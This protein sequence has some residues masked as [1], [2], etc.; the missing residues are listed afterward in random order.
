MSELWYQKPAIGWDEALPVGNGRLGAML[1]EDSVWY[2]GP[3][4]RL[5]EDALKNLPRLRELIRQG[6]HKQAEQLRH[7]EPLGTLSLEFGHSF[8]QVASYR[9]S[10]DLNEGIAHVQ[11]EYNGVQFHRQVLASHPDG[12]LAIRIQASRHTEFLVRL[13][14]LSDLEYE[15][16]EFLDELSVDDRSITMQVTPGGKDSNRA[17]CKVAIRCENGD[18]E[19]ARIERVG[20]NLVVTARDVLVLVA[21]Q[22]TYRHE[23]IIRA[24]TADLDAAL[25]YSIDDIWRRHIT[26][27][28]ALYGRLELQLSPDATYKPTDER[29]K[30]ERDPGLFALYLH[31]S[32]YLLISCSRP[33]KKDGSDRVLPAT[34]QGIW[35]PSFHPPWGC[36]YTININLQ[37]NYWPANVGNLS[38]CERPLFSL[39]ERLA[40]TGA[41]T[42]RKM[43]GCRGWTVHH[44]TDIWADTAP[45]D[46]WMP[47][48]LWPLGGAWLCFHIWEHFRFTGDQIS[49]AHLFPV[50]RGCVEFL[51][52]F[53]V[54]D[55]SGQY[56]V[57]NPSL[58]P[59]NT[60]RAAQGEAGVLCEGSTIDVQL[61]RA[62]L[63]AFVAA[64]EVLGLSQDELLP[65]VKE[66]LLRLPPIRIGSAGQLQEWMSDY[67]EL[68]PGHRHVSHLWALYPGKDITVDT[69]PELAKACAVTLRR[70][71]AAGG[72]HTGWS[73]AW[74]L[75]L[76]ARLRDVNECSSHLERLL[77]DST[78]PNLLDTHPPFQIDGNFGGGAG[79][80]EMLVQSH[81]DGIIRL[82]PACPAAWKTGRLRG[83]RARGG[84]ELEFGWEDG[85]I[86]GP[87]IV[88]SELGLRAVVHYPDGAR[89]VMTMDLTPVEDLKGTL[90]PDFFH[91]YATAAPQVEGA[92]NKDGK[93]LSIWDTFGHTPGKVKDGSTAD[94]AVRSYDFFREDV[95]LMKSYGVNAYRFSLS[96]SRIIPLGGADDP[97]NELG[98]K[99]YQ[100]LIEELLR[101][102]I[103]PFVTLF[104]WDVPQALED[105][106]GGMLNQ[107]RF[108]PDFVRYARVCFERLGP[109]VRHWITFNEPGVY[110]LAGYAAGVHA[111]ARS[112]FR[113]LNEEGDSSTEPFTVSHTELIAHAYASKLYKEEFKSIQN[114]TIGITLHGNWSEAFS[115]SEKD[116]E[117]AERAREF[118]IAWFADPL[119]KTGDYPASMRA[120]LGDRLPRFTP[121]ESGLVLGSSEFYGMNSYTTF[122]VEHKDTPADI[123][124]HKGNIIVH[125]TNSKGESRGEESDTPW[126]RMAPVGFRKLLNWIW[127]RY[128]VPI[129]VTENGT[130]AKGETA[131]TPEVLNDTFRIRF[132]EGYV[133]GLARAVKED[134]VDI[135]SYFGWTFTDNWE[136]GMFPQ[137]K[138]LSRRSYASIPR[139]PTA[140]RPAPDIKHIRQNPELYAENCRNRN[141]P[142]QADYPSKIQQLSDEIRQIDI[143][144][145]PSRSRI[146]ALEK[147]IGRLQNPATDHKEKEQEP[148]LRAE[149]Q[150]LKNESQT[151]TTRMASYGEQINE[152]ALSLPNL[153]SAHTPVGS[154]PALIEYLNFDPQSPP[155]WVHHSDSSRSHVAIGSALGLIDFASAATTTGWGWYFLTGE[156]AILEQALIQYSLSVARRHGWNPVSPPSIVYSYVADACGFQPRDQNNE[157][158]I[159]AIEQAEKDKAKPQRSLAATAEI[160]LAAMHAGR[161]FDA[162]ALPL[163][164]VGPSR[165]YR[166][167]AG[168]RGVDTK[169]L[170]RVHEFTKVEMF[171]WAD[172]FP[173]S[174]TPTSDDL[175]DN[176]L[177]VQKEILTS[178]RLPCRILEMPTGDLGASATRKRDIEALF[179]SRLRGEDFESAWGEVTSA[180]ICTDY[181]SRRLGTRVRR[182]GAKETRFPHTVNGTAMAVPRV[183]A[184]ILENGWDTE[185]RVVVIP[186]VLR[187]F[188]GGLE[189]IGKQNP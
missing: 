133:G 53:L 9:R 147:T 173:A 56:K 151:L 165:C 81:E 91:G 172:N 15:T 49:L 76:H 94:D 155:S 164:L 3:Q 104:H 170:Y 97:V 66:T 122:F 80:L 37:M 160:P 82:L 143:Q 130:T 139:P 186:E 161:E 175:F 65:S 43:Y 85:A 119:Y 134:G 141:Y 184:A 159:W 26:D 61:V 112:S 163:K 136:Y 34:L 126:L 115:E 59:E 167:E 169:G 31:Y 58:S 42:A 90:R 67:D 57:T 150:Q 70:R 105:R 176:L 79:I 83:V 148:A 110:S 13:S 28:Q 125:D 48:T 138:S 18:Q 88:K 109:R 106:Y 131:P 120:Q 6:D 54:D 38:E 178:L 4:D 40:V 123:N 77:A 153:S 47:A 149:A 36:R 188:M 182:N 145:K 52:D 41:E 8:D 102:G 171:G 92:W 117:A 78:L 17:S 16:N 183:L 44:N 124:D 72:G 187:P 142:T 60:Y 135:R 114:G 180:S 179:P 71:Q 152:L 162:S 118:E 140:P 121:E 7:C 75:N 23:N 74:L 154:E 24:T 62:V 2:G 100:D 128:H 111:P 168:S 144:L 189:V 20:K 19:S 14:R 25:A 68:E 89:K 146:K 39:L 93:G 101:N 32:R 22:T 86:Q 30:N 113:D 156:G 95:A 27:Y 108:V 127:N 137:I 50:L 45:V 96:W 116:Q 129:Y 84:F 87:V 11:Y 157:Q 46:R 33:G 5:P 107:E 177:T 63:E 174:S 69:T 103:T 55:A 166:A 99:Y 185:N 12:V 51:V 35:N 29:I 181:Q 158:Q 98:I 1:N 73:R 10:L 64:L 21:A 132:F